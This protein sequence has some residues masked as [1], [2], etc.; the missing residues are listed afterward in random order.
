MKRILLTTSTICLLALA[1]AQAAEQAAPSTKE[2]KND[3]KAADANAARKEAG[4]KLQK[5]LEKFGLFSPEVAADYRK[6]S[7]AALAAGDLDGAIEYAMFTLKVEMKLQKEDDP[8][9][10][11][12]Y[13]DTGNLYYK[14]KQHPTAVLYIEKA[15]TIYN[16][17]KGKGSLAL[18]DTYEALASIF[19][20][21]QDLEKSLSYNEKALKIRK[22]KLPKGD[23]ALQRS[24]MNDSYLRDE[25]KKKH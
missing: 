19:I 10:A 20:N 18:A 12:L 23:E 24:M 11:K 3:T 25:L 14:H 5:D 13:F 21:L 8:E 17:G 2:V 1:P 4:E 15:A 22:E 6:I 16:A 7:Q 9:L